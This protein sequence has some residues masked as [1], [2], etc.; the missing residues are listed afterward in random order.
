VSEGRSTVQF[1]GVQLSAR[2]IT[3]GSRLPMSSE[4]SIR[5]RG[6]FERRI[7]PGVDPSN[8]TDLVPD[9]G[10]S[11]VVGSDRDPTRQEAR[12]DGDW[13][14]SCHEPQNVAE[15]PSHCPDGTWLEPK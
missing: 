4:N 1:P 15:I 6:H 5:S 3:D 13:H 2:P 12:H 14:H 10:R 7:V 8:R 11:R 9:T